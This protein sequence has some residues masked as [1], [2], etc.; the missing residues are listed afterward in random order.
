MLNR[1]W[2]KACCTLAQ[3]TEPCGQPPTAEKNGS[4]CSRIRRTLRLLLIQ[5]PV[6]EVGVLAEVV[7]VPAVVAVLVAAEPVEVAGAAEPDNGQVAVVVLMAHQAEVRATDQIVL[8][9]PIDLADQAEKVVAVLKVAA[10]LNQKARTDHALVDL[11]LWL[12]F[13]NV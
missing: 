6:A 10:M 13:C 7:Q 11:T 3:L 5:L 12:D 4:T 1:P 2:K 9:A 8:K